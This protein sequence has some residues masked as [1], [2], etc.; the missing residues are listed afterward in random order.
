MARQNVNDDDNEDPNLDKSSKDGIILCKLKPG[1]KTMVRHRIDFNNKNQG[2]TTYTKRHINETALSVNIFPDHF[3]LNIE[4]IL[5]NTN[6]NISDIGVDTEI[7]V[8]RMFLRVDFG[9]ALGDDENL[10]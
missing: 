4:S 7:T 1:D 8:I 2:P 5:M 9:S 10:A 3:F 6:G